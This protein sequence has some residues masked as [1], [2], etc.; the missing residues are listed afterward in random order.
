MAQGYATADRRYI[1]A[2]PTFFERLGRAELPDA[3]RTPIAGVLDFFLE[4]DDETVEP[5]RDSFDGLLNFLQ[6]Y[7]ELPLPSIGVNRD[8][9][10]VAV[11]QNQAFRLSYEFLP[12]GRVFWASTERQPG[13][14]LVR[15][16]VAD[17]NSLPSEF[18]C[19]RGTP[20]VPSQAAR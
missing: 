20:T 6:R 11:W 15:D 8:G 3:V 7:R 18:A 13:R 14:I 12:T 16:G 4:D 19:L 1:G 17:V 10:F 5:S 9:R 2:A